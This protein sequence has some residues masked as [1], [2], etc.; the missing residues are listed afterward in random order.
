MNTTRAEAAAAAAAAAL[1]EDKGFPVD[2]GHIGKT[3]I[4]NV[5][6]AIAIM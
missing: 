3:C 1:V 5:M 4:T 6:Q 2:Q